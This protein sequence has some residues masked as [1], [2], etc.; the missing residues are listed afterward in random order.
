MKKLH[1]NILIYGISYETLIGL[2]S[3]RNRFY[4]IDGFIRN[5]DGT[6]YLGS[7]KYDAICDRIRYHISLKSGIT[8][9]FLTQ[10]YWMLMLII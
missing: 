5:Y 6:R 1:E 9:N 2:N 4:K 10:K 7:E 8:Y 3:L